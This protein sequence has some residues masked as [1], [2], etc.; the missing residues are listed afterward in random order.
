MWVFKESS[1]ELGGGIFSRGSKGDHFFLQQGRM[2]DKLEADYSSAE[3]EGDQKGA[4]D[5]GNHLPVKSAALWLYLLGM[6]LNDRLK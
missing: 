1:A 4:S 2:G 6:F 5:L 3:L